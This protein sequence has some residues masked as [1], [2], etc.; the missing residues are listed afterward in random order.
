MATTQETI[1]ATTTALNAFLADGAKTLY[2]QEDVQINRDGV[3]QYASLLRTIND[4]QALLDANAGTVQKFRA[5]C[6]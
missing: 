6:G 1:D 2:R 3:A 5:I 4:V